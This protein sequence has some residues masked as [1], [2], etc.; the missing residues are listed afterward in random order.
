MGDATE[1]DRAPTRRDYP[2]PVPNGRKNKLGVAAVLGIVTAGIAV[3]VWLGVPSPGQVY[4]RSEAQAAHSDLRSESTK[5]H[6]TLHE[7]IS[8]TRR[9]ANEALGEVKD[10]LR[11][12][13]KILLDIYR[14]AKKP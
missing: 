13:R 12:Q 7:R 9:E 6:E 10:E 11:D 2:T 4:T 3:L 14:E 8:S 5:A 1:R